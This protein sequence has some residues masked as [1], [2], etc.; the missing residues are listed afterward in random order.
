MKSRGPLTRAFQ[1][2]LGMLITNDAMAEALVAGEIEADGVH[3]GLTNADV[4][5]LNELVRKNS[6]RLLAISRLTSQRRRARV[7]KLLPATARIRK[8]SIDREWRQYLT[9]GIG[10]AALPLLQVAA[11]FARYLLCEEALGP[12]RQFIQFEYCWTDVA[13][14]YE[15]TP[16]NDPDVGLNG[17][18]REGL[19]LSRFVRI[20]QF[21]FAVDSAM[22]Q[23]RSTGILQIEWPPLPTLI[24]FHMR[25]MQPKGI[26]TTR[27][28]EAMAR[29]LPALVSGIEVQMLRSAT[30]PGILPSLDRMLADLLDRR[31][32]EVMPV[33]A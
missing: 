12:A 31:I 14:R 7:L 15:A 30:P 6:G 20:E 13:S 2:A 27:L 16:V 32:L 23:F 28:P 19:R 22:R 17:A 1:T 25:Q 3:P 21:D 26:T 18:V 11:N 9:V 5:A 10:R 29:A 24:V 4:H 33:A 8:S